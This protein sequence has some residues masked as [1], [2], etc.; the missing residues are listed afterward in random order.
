MTKTHSDDTIQLSTV[1]GLVRSAEKLGLS[2]ATGYNMSRNQVM[3][4]SSVFELADE[5][6]LGRTA[7]RRALAGYAHI[8]KTAIEHAVSKEVK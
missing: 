5:I 1:K 3:E 7:T 4:S 8:L 2:P 6:H